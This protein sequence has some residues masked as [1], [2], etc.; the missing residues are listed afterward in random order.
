ML[1]KNKQLEQAKVVQKLQE[2]G[3]RGTWLACT[4]V[5]KTKLGCDIADIIISKAKKL[6]KFAKV[7]I[8]VPTENLRDNEWNNELIKWGYA[9]LKSHIEIQCIQTVYKYLNRHY[10]LVI[11]DELH[12]TLSEQYSNF[13]RNN[14]YE[15]I[16]GLT[17]TIE[18][19]YKANLLSDFAPVVHKTSVEDA[20]RM[21]LIS[22]FTIYNL[23]VPFT[24]EE[25]KKY[26][27]INFLYGRAESGLGGKFKSFETA[28]RYRDSKYAKTNPEMYKHAQ[29]FWSQMGNRRRLLASASL[30][31]PTTKAIVDKFPDRYTLLFSEAVQM[32]ED[33]Q[34]NINS[35]KEICTIFHSDTKKLK[36]EVKNENLSKFCDRRNKIRVL[37]TVKALNAG[38][39]IPHCSLG[40]CI[41]GSSK[42][43]TD[44]QRRGRVCRLDP[45]DP[46]KRAIYVNL[47]V[48]KTQEE[49][50]L[51]KRMEGVD[52]T[53]IRYINSVN[54]II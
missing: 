13:F 45:N 32:A 19:E 30:K 5:G 38:L 40:I 14:T 11:V 21:E 52:A 23:A 17:A 25:Q 47:Y 12:T 7:L 8:I 6:K 43:L 31:I 22:P 2:K 42:T 51:V 16:V 44:I 39:N 18:D 34:I 9:S 20:L 50:W 48:P 53:N 54:E 35:D 24:E 4:G 28:N 41:A 3:F 1:N 10:D 36:K 27:A 37:S 46:N 15:H 29:M 26:K 49:K 33:L